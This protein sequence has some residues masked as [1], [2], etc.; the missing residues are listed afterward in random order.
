MA[1]CYVLFNASSAPAVLSLFT[2][3]RHPL[4]SASRSIQLGG[5]TAGFARRGIK[6]E[7]VEGR[8]EGKEEWFGSANPKTRREAAH[9][10][11]G[12]R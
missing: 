2:P 8:F 3:T 12:T 10:V 9:S 11:S 5:C 6:V 7:E 1:N 4:P